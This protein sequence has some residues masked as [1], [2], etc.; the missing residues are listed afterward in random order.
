VLSGFLSAQGR[1]NAVAYWVVSDHFEELGRPSRLFHNGFGLLTVGNLRKPRYWAVHL[2]EHMGDAVLAAHLRG[3][4]AGTLVQ[5]WATRHSD[6]T[7]DILAW[8]GTI[9]AELMDGDPRLDRSVEVTVTGLGAATYQASLARVDQRHS[10]VVAHCPPDVTWPD[11]ALWARLREADRLHERPLPDVTP[12]GG[13][14]RFDIDLPMPGIAR[15][16]LS[17]GEAPARYE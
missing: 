3:D 2:A 8:N 14:A 9:N 12:D 13:T 6:G 4:G 1:L 5:A 10:N 7:I 16:R 11:E 17:A 15:I